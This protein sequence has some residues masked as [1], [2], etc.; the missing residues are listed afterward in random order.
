MD[1]IAEKLDVPDAVIKAIELY[2]N[3][4]GVIDHFFF[5]VPLDRHDDTWHREAALASLDVSDV[6]KVIGT[7]V[8]VSTFLGNLDVALKPA[9][10]NA[11]GI[12]NVDGY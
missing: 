6:E 5:D 10:A 7:P 12:P 11:W 2:R 1:S 8:S 9:G 3:L 4:G